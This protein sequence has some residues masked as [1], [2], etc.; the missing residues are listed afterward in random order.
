MAVPGRITEARL[1]DPPD[2]SPLTV[3]QAFG[4][5]LQVRMTEKIMVWKK[6]ALCATVRPK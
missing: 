6:Q 4:E 2:A 1:V 5:S 3:E